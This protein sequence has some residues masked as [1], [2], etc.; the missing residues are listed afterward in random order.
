MAKS[1]N[2]FLPFIAV[3]LPTAG[4]ERMYTCNK[5]CNF[6]S[7]RMTHEDTEDILIST[8]VLNNLKMKT[9]K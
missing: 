6:S 7:C 5:G 4:R 3:W 1:Q 9:F 8:N 2:I